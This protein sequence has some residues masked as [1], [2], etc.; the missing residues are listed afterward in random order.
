LAFEEEKKV[1]TNY[2]QKNNLKISEQKIKILETF[3]SSRR[4][5]TADE[6]YRVVKKKR[7]SI[8]IATVYRN[9]KLFCKSGIC[10]ELRLDDGVIR[11][12][13]LY[14]HEHHDHLVCLDCGKVVEVVDKKIEELQLKIA[15]R[16][17]FIL[18]NH[19]LDM[20]GICDECRKKRGH[21]LF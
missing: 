7:P 16:N 2:I 11:Y 19:R 20:Y 18:K 21:D 6:L 8:G 1:L 5:I 4:H 15:K 10:R 17:H 3:L 13:A 9:L 14:G 12:E